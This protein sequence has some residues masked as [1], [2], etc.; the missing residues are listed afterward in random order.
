MIEL[1]RHMTPAQKIQRVQSLNQLLELLAM[2]DV[3]KQ[4]PT[5]DE[6]ECFLRVASRRLPPDL[7]SKVYGWSLEEEGY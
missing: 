5:A 6:R 7:M 3:Q 2:A 1:L 4:H